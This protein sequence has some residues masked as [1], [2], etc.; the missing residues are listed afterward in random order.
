MGEDFTGS[1]GT[2]RTVESEEEKEKNNFMTLLV[3]DL[4]EKPALLVNYIAIFRCVD[5]HTHTHV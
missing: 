4:I 1:Q 2:Q 3:R 5:T